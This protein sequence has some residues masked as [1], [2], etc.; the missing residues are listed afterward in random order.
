MQKEAESGKN[1]KEDTD[2]FSFAPSK[3]LT[4]LH[5]FSLLNPLFCLFSK[6]RFRVFRPHLT[7]AQKPEEKNKIRTCSS[8]P[9]TN[10][11]R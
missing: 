2:F 10:N 6:P 7:K 11:V 4:S 8:K 3:T 5:A 1:R 9:T